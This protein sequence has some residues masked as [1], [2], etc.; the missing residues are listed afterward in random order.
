MIRINIGFALLPVST[1]IFVTFYSHFQQG[2]MEVSVEM[3]IAARGWHVYCKTVWRNPQTGEKLVAEKEKNRNALDIDPYAMAWM[4]KRKYKL[5]ADIV[6]HVP[7]E[8]SRFVWFVFTHGGKMEAPVLQ[9]WPLPSPTPSGGLE[10]LLTAKLTIDEKH[11]NIVKCSS[12]RIAENYKPETD[13]GELDETDA[14]TGHWHETQEIEEPEHE[15]DGIIFLE[16]EED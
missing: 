15:I 10:I 7:R 6:G 2:N 12:Q 9:I 16:D 3:T 5:T 1:R 8:I 4:L 13:L 14:E 11:M